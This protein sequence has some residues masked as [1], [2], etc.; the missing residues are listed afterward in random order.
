MVIELVLLVMGLVGSY[1][2]GKYQ[3]RVALEE[4]RIECKADLLEAERLLSECGGMS[5][6]PE[7]G[8]WPADT[9]EAY[10]DTEI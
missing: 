4:D 8:A 2:F 7:D 5:I 9:E 6:E 1:H 3:E 10:L